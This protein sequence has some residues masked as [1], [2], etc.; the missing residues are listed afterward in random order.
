MKGKVFTLGVA[1]S[2]LVLILIRPYVAPQ[3]GV[4]RVYG[5][6]SADTYGNRIVGFWVATYNDTL[7]DYQF[8]YGQA[9]Y[10]VTYDGTNTFDGMNIIADT[11]GVTIL[12]YNNG[13]EVKVYG[14]K[15]C[16]II[17]KVGAN[18]TLISDPE[19]ETRV[20]LN[21]TG[22]VTNQLMTYD[23][24]ST[25]TNFYLITYYYNWTSN[26]PSEGTSYTVAVKFE[27]YY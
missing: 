14:G 18:K 8:P 23:G 3:F 7:G 22:V 15:Q 26:L 9:K 17:V 13:V 19:T 20:Y 1:V 25:G 10:A 12:E 5:A 6:G 24:Y 11:T 21:I 16:K 27:T 2:L 4:L